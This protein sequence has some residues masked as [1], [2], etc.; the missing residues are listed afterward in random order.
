MDDPSRLGSEAT[1]Y[2]MCLGYQPDFV[3][4]NQMGEGPLYDRQAAG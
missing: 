3:R 1:V 2:D 4:H